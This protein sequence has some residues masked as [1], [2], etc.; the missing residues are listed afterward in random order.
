ML[1][2]DLI[3]RAPVLVH[4]E[5]TLADAV[6]RMR[7]ADVGSVVV[8]EKE[9]PVGILTDRDVALHLGRGPDGWLVEDVMTPTPVSI[10]AEADVEL[11]LDRMEE[12]GI[13]RILIMEGFTIVGVVSLDDILMHLG[14]L[15]GKA[16]S[17]IR[18]EIAPHF[19]E[20]L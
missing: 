1:A 3:T 2:Q 13:R 12:H 17:L 8:A 6:R 9:E 10:P 7:D 4:R 16:S 18:A 20:E 5:A 15:M 19:A 14:Y 11:C